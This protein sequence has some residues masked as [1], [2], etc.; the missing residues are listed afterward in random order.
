MEF[1]KD[2]VKNKVVWTK[3]A[4]NCNGSQTWLQPKIIPLV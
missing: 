2:E 4:D 3:G 1:H